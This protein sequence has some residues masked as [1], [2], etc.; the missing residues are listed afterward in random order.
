[1]PYHFRWIVQDYLLH[2]T[3]D[4]RMTLAEVLDAIQQIIEIFDD[5]TCKVYIISDV[6]N[7]HFVPNL[8]DSLDGFK[9]FLSHPKR[10]ILAI[11]GGAPLLKLAL[12]ISG[13]P[14]DRIHFFDDVEA[15]IYYIVRFAAMNGDVFSVPPSCSQN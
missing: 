12:T 9:P 5:S 8:T 4:Q 10:G 14:V 11:V 13:Y 3:H 7:A 15:A 1:M 2:V 6:S